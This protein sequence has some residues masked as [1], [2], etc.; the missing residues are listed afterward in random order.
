MTRPDGMPT[1]VMWEVVGLIHQRLP[2]LY[3][4]ACF[5]D[6]DNSGVMAA[7]KR[8]WRP[9]LTTEEWYVRAWDQLTSEQPI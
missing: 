5:C 7:V 2:Q 3:A 8:A 9:E 1:H 4:T 6:A